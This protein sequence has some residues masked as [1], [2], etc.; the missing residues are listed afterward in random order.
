MSRNHVPPGTSVVFAPFGA[1]HLLPIAGLHDATTGRYG[2]DDYQLSF[3]PSL[4]ALHAVYQ[5][6]RSSHGPSSDVRALTVAHPGEP[7]T[8]TYLS[9][10]HEE[11]AAVSRHFPGTVSLTGSD[12]TPDAVISESPGQHVIHFG[13]HAA[14]EFAR[15][16][17]SG[18]VLVG[19]RLTVQRIIAE[20]KLDRTR[21]VTLA[22][23]MTGLARPHDGDEPAGLAHAFL[24]GGAQAVVTRMWAVADDATRALME[25]F[26][27]RLAAGDNAGE[28]LRRAMF[29]V[30]ESP[31]W[32][33]PL[34]WAGFHVIGLAGV[35]L[36]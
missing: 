12:A 17:Q 18:L 31:G 13:C 8:R 11:A 29:A 21:V 6:A 19:G 22:A 32:Q 9:H 4:G 25:A 15:P 34:Y 16:E 28:A 3:A 36:Q 23:C 20:L 26:Y 2:A 33:D 10:V 1:L 30:R 5:Q 35:T 27:S 24:V 14:F 7:G